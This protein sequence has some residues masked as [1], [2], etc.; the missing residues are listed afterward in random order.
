MKFSAHARAR[1]RRYA[2]QALYQWELSGQDLGEIRRQ[3][4]EDDEFARADVPYFTELLSQI[5]AQVDV[6]DDRLA[7]HLDRPVAQVDPVEKAILRIAFYELLF[8]DDVPYRVI[9]NEAVALT[10]KFGAEQGHAFVNGVLDH[11][12]HKIRPVE[13]A[14]RGE[15]VN[16][17]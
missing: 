3:F 1:A 6:I 5:P 13:C 2:L 14:A 12:A 11:A 10:K 16:G 15:Q 7:E 8:R 17:L 4:A 9:I